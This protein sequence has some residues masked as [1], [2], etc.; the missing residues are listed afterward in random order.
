MEIEHF[1]ISFQWMGKPFL[2]EVIGVRVLQLKQLFC[3]VN[4]L[5]NSKFWIWVFY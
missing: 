2:T 1:C 4:Y 5:A 3:L